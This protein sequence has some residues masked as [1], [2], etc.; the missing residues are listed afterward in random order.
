[1][2]LLLSGE[3]LSDIGAPADPAAPAGAAGLNPGPMARFVEK[4]VAPLWQYSP[5]DGQ[6]FELIT[7]SVLTA[8]CKN[9]LRGLALRGRKRPADTAYF[10]KNARGLACLARERAQQE[11]CEVGA[12]LFRDCDGTNASPS[13]LWA[14]K[15][16]SM[17]SGFAAESFDL[18]VPMVPNPKSEA[19]LLCA[20]QDDPYCNCGRYEALSGND[21]SPNSAK[22]QLNEALAARGCSYADVC[23]MVESGVIDPL[24][25]HMPSFDRFRERLADVALQMARNPGAR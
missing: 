16:S 24:R 1:M 5:L 6:G 22:R 14:D 12:V 7:E 13:T 3:G 10:F 8:Y 15:V 21:A 18:G 17:E 9:K 2:I 19:W 20:A 4:L 11:R 23:G 25:I